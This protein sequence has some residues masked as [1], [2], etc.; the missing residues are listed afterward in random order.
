[1]S[2]SHMKSPNTEVQFCIGNVV[3]ILISKGV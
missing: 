1:M 3:D 2:D